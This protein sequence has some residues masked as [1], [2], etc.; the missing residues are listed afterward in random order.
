MDRVDKYLYT[1]PW[2]VQK[3]FMYMKFNSSDDTA[4]KL[5]HYKLTR[6]GQSSFLTGYWNEYQIYRFCTTY[7]YVS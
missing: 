3:S 4:Y 6:I 7:K 1:L 2:M 5:F